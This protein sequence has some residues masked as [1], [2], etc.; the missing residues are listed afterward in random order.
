MGLVL[1]FTGVRGLLG[2]PIVFPTKFSGWRRFSGDSARAVGG[3]AFF[4]GVVCLCVS[5][6]IRM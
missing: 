1:L 4:F 6:A 2:F 3:V 5:Y